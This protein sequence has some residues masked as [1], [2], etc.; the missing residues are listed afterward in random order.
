MLTNFEL[1]RLKPKLDIVEKADQNR[2]HK[3]L[4]VIIYNKIGHHIINQDHI[5]TGPTTATNRRRRAPPSRLTRCRYDSGVAAHAGALEL[6]L[7]D[8]RRRRTQIGRRRAPKSYFQLHRPT[9]D[10]ADF[11]YCVPHC[12]HACSMHSIL[13]SSLIWLRFLKSL[14]YTV[15]RHVHAMFDGAA[16]LYSHYELQ[17]SI[18][19]SS[20]FRWVPLRIKLTITL[21]L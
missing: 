1:K 13:Y 5:L 9:K 11:R 16:E 21:D 12:S 20:V 7:G 10:L 18:F 19:F 17:A 3:P 4:I 2:V 6:E 8:R 15:L 14:L